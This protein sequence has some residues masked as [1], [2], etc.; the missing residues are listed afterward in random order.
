M[1]YEVVFEQVIVNILRETRRIVLKVISNVID[2]GILKVV[3]VGFYMTVW[4]LRLLL[5]KLDN[6][7][8]DVL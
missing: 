7:I 2:V 6:F 8:I 3:Y 1:L 5:A 4:H